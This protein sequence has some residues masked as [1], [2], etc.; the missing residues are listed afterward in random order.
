V[1]DPPHSEPREE[2]FSHDVTGAVSAKTGEP[3]VI[4]EVL[5]ADGHAYR[6][7]LTPA[8]SHQHG[9]RMIS[10]AIEA[11]RDAGM[12]AF[13]QSIGMGQIEIGGLLTGMRK[14]RRQHDVT[15]VDLNARE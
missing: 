13:L 1:T 10:A 8:E 4:E 5:T 6:G 11:E 9:W 3:F 14:H 12:V 7:Q 15:G 2:G